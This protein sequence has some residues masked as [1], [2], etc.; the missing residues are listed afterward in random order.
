MEV[1]EWL[2]GGIGMEWASKRNVG[3]K[4]SIGKGT[5]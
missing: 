2:L 3:K 1:E 4:G 5:G